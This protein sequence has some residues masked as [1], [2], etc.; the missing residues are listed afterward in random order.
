MDPRDIA[1]FLILDGRFPRS[2]TFCADK[3]RTNMAGLAKQYGAETQA[4]QRLR[5]A[6]DQLNALTIEQIF[7]RG[8]H[9]FL[10]DFI[11]RTHGISQAIAADYR[12]TA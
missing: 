10:Q 5:E 11:A 6:V 9:E 8:L 3:I 2:L 1:R 12:F 4:H 7:E